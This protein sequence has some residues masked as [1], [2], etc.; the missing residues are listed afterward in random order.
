MKLGQNLSR[1]IKV[2]DQQVHSAIPVLLRVLV[3]EEGLHVSVR[4]VGSLPLGVWAVHHAPLRLRGLGEAVDGAAAPGQ[5][6]AQPQHEADPALHVVT[7]QRGGAAPASLHAGRREL[8]GGAAVVRGGGALLGGEGVHQ[9]Q[10]EGGGP[11]A[12]EVGQRVEQRHV[13]AAHRGVRHAGEE[14]HD[15]DKHRV[16]SNLGRKRDVN[17]TRL[18]FKVMLCYYT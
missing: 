2:T 11:V 5:Q 7:V 3:Q 12:A 17:T 10:R 6:P 13:G 14:C 18:S 8:G 4:G 9:P 1:L 16:Q 15:G